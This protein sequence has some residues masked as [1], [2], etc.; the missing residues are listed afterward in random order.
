MFCSGGRRIRGEKKRF[1]KNDDRYLY[2]IRYRTLDKERW[3]VRGRE[4]G[5]GGGGEGGTG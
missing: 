4:G 3:V 1:A 2:R 5:V